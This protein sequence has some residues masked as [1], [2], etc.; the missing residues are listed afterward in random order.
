MVL[1]AEP[2]GLVPKE[3]IRMVREAE[4]AAMVMEEPIH[5]VLE[6]RLA[7]AA[8]TETTEHMEGPGGLITPPQRR[9]G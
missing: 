6:V 1:G 7:A 9:Q 5:M 4:P 3:P 8:L 2:A